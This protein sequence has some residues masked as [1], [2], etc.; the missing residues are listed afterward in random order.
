[1]PKPLSSHKLN[2]GKPLQGDTQPEP[3]RCSPEKKVWQ[4]LIQYKDIG[5]WILV[6]LI[7]SWC[8]VRGYHW[9]QNKREHRILTQLVKA[10]TLADQLK[11]AES[12][13]LPTSLKNLSGSIFL[14]AGHQ[15]YREKSFGKAAKYYGLA[16]KQLYL[17]PFL[18][19]AKKGYAFATLQ[20]GQKKEAEAML[21][22]LAIDKKATQVSQQEA[23]YTLAFLAYIDKNPK[24]LE[25]YA[26]QL[27]PL[28]V[29]GNFLEN[30]EILKR[31]LAH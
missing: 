23:L 22:A 25:E 21:H 18:E 20:A 1:M 28:D 6:V 11:W 3:T 13:K 14:K 5:A 27:K 4:W 26:D 10:S 15:A 31:T 17:S 19:Q 8:F 7:C 30:I 2:D 29:R 24:K 12:K 9:V 16:I